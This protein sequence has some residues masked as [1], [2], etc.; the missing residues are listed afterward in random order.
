VALLLTGTALFAPSAILRLVI[1][2]RAVPDRHGWWASFSDPSHPLPVEGY[3]TFLAGLQTVPLNPDFRRVVVSTLWQVRETGRYQLHFSAEAHA[4]LTL[5]G[6][7]IFCSAP[8]SETGRIEQKWVRLRRGPHLVRLELDN[9]Q[10]GGWFSIGVLTPPLMR[11]APLG[12]DKITMVRLGSLDTWWWILRLCPLLALA[13]GTVG[14]LAGLALLLPLASRNRWPA[15]AVTCLLVLAPALLVPDLS[16][17]EPYIG[18]MVHRRLKAVRPRFVF[19]GNSMLWSRIDD[20]LLSRLLGGVPVF[21]IVNF[22]GMS[23]IH[24]LAIKYLLIPSGVHP[25]KVFIFFRGT[26]LLDPSFRTTGRYFDTLIKRISPGPDPVFERLAHGRS[27]G[28]AGAAD[29]WLERI[30]RVQANGR[31]VRDL[32]SRAAFRLAAFIPAVGRQGDPA[33][34]RRQVNDRFSLNRMAGGMDREALRQSRGV[35]MPEDFDRAA[36]RSFLPPMFEL[37]REN[38]FQLVFIRVQERPPARGPVKDPPEMVRF[39]ARL[40]DYLEA[41]GALLYDFTGDPELTLSLYGQGDHIADPR[42]YTP[43]F[44]R[45]LRE[46][47]R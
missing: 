42:R 29:R 8:R 6:R 17:R 45:R 9:E 15:V 36:A 24:Y 18:P 11:F 20:Q 41:H 44:H 7:T 19:V 25:E 34:L 2:P 26:T 40:K 22:G 3:T 35:V 4:R 12:G 16:R 32:V 33:G 21:S 46:L 13:A 27:V 23:A 31:P 37:A 47:L 10:G 39:M 38:G 14:V 43:I 1:A 5:D 30:F 28:Q